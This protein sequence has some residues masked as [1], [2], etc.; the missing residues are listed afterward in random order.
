M[1]MSS[2]V[3]ANTATADRTTVAISQRRFL[4]GV[5]ESIAMVKLQRLQIEPGAFVGMAYGIVA[6]RA[7]HTLGMVVC[8]VSVNRLG[9][10]LV[11]AAAGRFRHSEIKI[12]DADGVGIPRGREVHGMEKTVARLDRVFPG[13]V[14][15]RVAIVA[16][17]GKVMARL[18]P[19]VILRAHGVTVRTRDRVILQIRITF[20]VNKGIRAHADKGSEKKRDDDPQDRG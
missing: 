6:T 5:P 10:V 8:H 13:Y 1:L 4:V 12:G 14:G 17:R 19:P 3:T 2:A 9:D 15:G 11:T 20:G 7:V 18:H 16:G